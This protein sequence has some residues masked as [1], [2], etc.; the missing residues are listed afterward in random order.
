MELQNKVKNFTI[1]KRDGVVILSINP[2]IYPLEVIYGASYVFLDKSYVII[3]GD[4]EKE[5]LVQLK[6]KNKGE[7]LEELA[8][9]F[10]NELVNYGMYVVQ[11]ARTSTI[12][13]AIVQAALSSVQNI[14]QEGSVVSEADFT[15]S[16]QLDFEFED[17]LGIAE[18][19]TPEKMKGL[20][21]PKELEEILREEAEKRSDKKEGKEDSVKDQ[22]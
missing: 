11:A 16:K 17:P 13:N 14:A 7:D 6:P 3:N 22:S 18:P 12:R 1:N 21:M 15:G 4:P 19:W 9:K 2:K 20:K 10:N 8:L 5:V